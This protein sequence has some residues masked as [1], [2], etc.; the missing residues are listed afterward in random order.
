MMFTAQTITDIAVLFVLASA[1]GA[2]IGGAGLLVV[3]LTLIH[4]MDQV[5]AQALN[6]A[7]FVLSALS[8]AAVQIKNRTLPDLRLIMFCSAAS[9]PGVFFGTYLR[10]MMSN[11]VLRMAFGALL[12][13]TAFIVL[14]KEFKTKPLLLKYHNNA[15]KK[16]DD[17]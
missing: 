9:I 6:L 16:K 13:I 17:R 3:Y 12:L 5:Q 2:G 8:S 11:D 4:G 7:F 10:N 1:A 15:K 14:R